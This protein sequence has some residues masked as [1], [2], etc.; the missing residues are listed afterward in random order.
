MDLWRIKELRYL[1]YYFIASVLLSLFFLIFRIPI[2]MTLQACFG[3][4]YVLFIPGYLASICLFNK[5]EISGVMRA[6]LS[7]A[8][9]IVIVVIMVIFSNNVLDILLTKLSCLVIVGIIITVLLLIKILV[10]KDGN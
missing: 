7:F 9:S 3:L 4:V 6:T 5:K 2:I 8:L 10:K 1:V